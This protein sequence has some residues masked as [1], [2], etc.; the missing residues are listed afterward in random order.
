MNKIVHGQEVGTRSGY[1]LAV[2]VGSERG[3]A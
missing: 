2:V 3:V 1:G